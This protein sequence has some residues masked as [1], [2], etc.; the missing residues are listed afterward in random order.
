MFGLITSSHANLGFAEVTVPNY[1]IKNIL[2]S[3]RSCS[4]YVGELQQAPAE[5]RVLKIFKSREDFHR[6]QSAL[7]VLRAAREDLQVPWI[8]DQ[9]VEDEDEDECHVLVVGPV[10]SPVRPAADGLP[11]NGPQFADLLEILHTAHSCNIVHRDVKPPNMFLSGDKIFLNDW[12]SSC[13]RDSLELF[14]GT[15]GYC[16]TRVPGHDVRY[17][18]EAD[19]RGLVRS[20]FAMYTGL[21]PPHSCALAEEFWA[22]HLRVN[23]LWWRA[24]EYANSLQYEELRLLLTQL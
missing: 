7:T 3:G 6:E 24:M 11:V 17:G 23:S 12:G 19:L 4:V 5:D 15:Y 16:D 9:V 8:Y 22:I 10:G 21:A 1:R 18:A 2:G 20:C 13:E 14:V